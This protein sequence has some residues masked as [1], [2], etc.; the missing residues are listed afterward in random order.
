MSQRQD[1][2]ISKNERSTEAE[3]DLFQKYDITSSPNDFNVRTIVDFIEQGVFRI[4]VFQRNYVWDLIRASKLIESIILGLPI[5]QLFLYEQERNSYLVID[6]QQ[7]LMTI[8][9]FLKM[10]FPVTGRRYELREIF[11]REGRIPSE[12][13]SNDDYFRKFNLR[14]PSRL[15]QER[16][17]LHDL[18]YE[19]LGHLR[20]TLDLKTMRCVLVRQNFPKEDDSSILEIFNRLNTGGMNLTPQEIRASLYNSD[21]MKMVS[22][23]NADSRW[24]SLI[25]QPEPD[26][27]MRDVEHLLR[28][29]AMLTRGAKYSPSMTRFLN[30]FAKEMQEESQNEI[31]LL[32]KMLSSFLDN[33]VDFPGGIFGTSSRRLN[34]SV[35]ESVFAAACQ[36]GYKD[37]SGHVR[38]ICSE[39]IASLKQDA[40]FLDAA[41]TKSTNTNKVRTRLSRA[42]R[43]LLD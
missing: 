36:T 21:F 7:R 19:T 29:F 11:D 24:R 8:Y 17:R 12:I 41:S 25:D 31:D 5:P 20:T 40:R 39:K 3:K 35:F 10:R 27:R 15:P 1:D 33:C 6:G 2:V 22:R 42:R 38:S 4:P 34:I 43:L 16:N 32:E 9:Y 37:G 23:F 13:F 26:L 18:N 14:L 30:Q 28:G